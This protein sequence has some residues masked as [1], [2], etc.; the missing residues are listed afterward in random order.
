M[1]DIQRD[2]KNVTLQLMAMACRAVQRGYHGSSRQAIEIEEY[3]HTD[4]HSH[5]HPRPPI[6]GVRA[7]MSQQWP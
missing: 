7:P 4:P 5:T 2:S 1:C 3:I 6:S